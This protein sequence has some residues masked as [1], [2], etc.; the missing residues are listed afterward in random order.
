[1]KLP[2]TPPIEPMLAKAVTRIRPG[3]LY[4]P[5]WD[6][7][8]A[9]V[10][11]DGDEVEIVSRNSRPLARYFPEV[12]A[13]VKEG[14]PHRCVVDGEVIIANPETGALDFWALQQRLHPAQSRVEL[15]AG[16]TPARLVLFDILA[17]ADE[18]LM[19]LPFRQRRD[20]LNR[21]GDEM[22]PPMHVTPLTGDME[23]AGRWFEELEGAGL[24]GIIA[25]NGDDPYQ[26]GRRV[27][28]KV[29][30]DRTADC[31]VIGY[32]A[33]KNDTGA[34]G[35]LILALHSDGDHPRDEWSDMFGGLVPIGVASSFPEARRRELMAE[36]QPLVIELDEHP[37]GDALRRIAAE[38]GGYPGSRWNPG[39]DLSFVPL[40]PELVAEVRYNH[41][42]RGHLRHPAQFLRWRPD[43]D[44]VSCGFSQLEVV[45]SVDVVEVLA[46]RN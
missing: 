18:G 30:H 35:S 38:A 31:V 34:I 12:V 42:D 26:P 10:F 16:R 14:L 36:L 44:P 13:A 27:M 29:K 19:S 32:R 9:I 15:L 22:S 39:K 28:E 3:W 4:E 24:D 2:V 37:W 45:D 7:F 6:G 41:M 25:K 21:I 40:Q 23:T 17:L 43:R 33:H 1:M 8:R 20:H 11:R 46:A 5:K